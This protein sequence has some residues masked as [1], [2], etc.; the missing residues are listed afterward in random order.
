MRALLSHSGDRLVKQN[1]RLI[2]N[3]EVQHWCA[4]LKFIGS[5]KGKVL[6]HCFCVMSKRYHE[7]SSLLEDSKHLSNWA[8]SAHSPVV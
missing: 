4:K 3:H 1:L 7:A 5:A 8:R 6:V 2:G